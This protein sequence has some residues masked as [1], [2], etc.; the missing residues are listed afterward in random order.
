MD[1]PHVNRR[2]QAIVRLDTGASLFL[3]HR[4][5]LGRQVARRAQAGCLMRA[6]T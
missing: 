4:D 5:H 3:D 2:H 1:H 6:C